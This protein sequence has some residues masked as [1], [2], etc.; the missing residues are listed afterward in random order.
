MRVLRRNRAA[1]GK[2]GIAIIAL[3]APIA[4]GVGWRDFSVEPHQPSASELRE[5]VEGYAH[6]IETNN[7]ELALWYVHPRSP[8]RSEIDESLREQLAYYQEKAKTSDLELTHLP[9][10]TISAEVDQELMRIFGLKITRSSRQMVFRFRPHGR[11][12][13]IWGMEERGAL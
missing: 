7:H 5:L 8:S 9:D 11:D 1:I 12:W 4:L 3:A 2:A 10:G 13:R 6:A